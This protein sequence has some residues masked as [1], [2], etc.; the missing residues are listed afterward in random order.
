M[1]DIARV[2]MVAGEASGDMLGAHLITALKARRS[3]MLFGG[4]GGPRMSGQGFESQFP[5]D[6]LS[7]RGYTEALRS[8]FEI[9]GIRRRLT[10]AMLA[11]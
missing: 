3:S 11:G 6:K 4:I 7:V 9:S 5:M 1:S 10:R 8:Y 2:G